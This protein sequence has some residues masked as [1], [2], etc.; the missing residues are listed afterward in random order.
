MRLQ[1]LLLLLLLFTSCA[2]AY[3]TLSCTQI[4]LVVTAALVIPS[5][6][7]L[8]S[9][10]KQYHSFEVVVPYQ[11]PQK[12]TIMNVPIKLPVCTFAD[13]PHNI[14]PVFSYADLPNCTHAASAYA[15]LPI[16]TY[17]GLQTCTNANSSTCIYA[18]LPTCNSTNLPTIASETNQTCKSET[19]T[20]KAA[21]TK[22]T[23]TMVT[24]ET[25][26]LLHKGSIVF[27]KVVSVNGNDVNCVLDSDLKG[28]ISVD[29]V[30][31]G[32]NDVLTI[33]RTLRC[34][35]T[36]IKR[37]KFK[38]ELNCKISEAKPYYGIDFYAARAQKKKMLMRMKRQQ[39]QKV[40][41]QNHRFM[42]HPLFQH[43]TRVDAEKYLKDRKPGDLVIRP[44]PRGGDYMVITCKMA[45]NI[46]QH[47]GIKEEKPHANHVSTRYTIGKL[48]FENLDKLII[49]Y[50]EAIFQKVNDLMAHPKF[51]YGG[52]SALSDYL[53]STT[54]SNPKIDAFGLCLNEKPGYFDLGYK[55]NKRSKMTHMASYLKIVTIIINLIK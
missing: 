5:L 11:E 1:I 33:G 51:Q 42:N 19:S 24:T 14:L 29:N 41:N 34:K 20:T 28:T 13:L 15:N 44:S 55:L 35:V 6:P 36:R 23:F 31:C 16:C 39:Q 25:D 21:N 12:N 9:F 54:R 48:V 27:A 52:Y 45:N 50:V 10:D 38:A 47:I 43:L 18:D 2:S 40:P 22:K 7:S 8:I 37:D 17:T 4:L 3:E 32:G 26:E 53:D 30:S 49:T 46:Y